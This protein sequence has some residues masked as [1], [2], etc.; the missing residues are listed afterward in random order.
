MRTV[1]EYIVSIFIIMVFFIAGLIVVLQIPVA[2]R[3]SPMEIISLSYPSTSGVCPGDVIP[4]QITFSIDENS[5]VI[6]YTAILD[7]GGNV[8]P[9]TES[10]MPPRP[11]AAG[12][13]LR[14][15]INF[16]VPDLQAGSYTRETAIA[17][18][19]HD[20]EVTMVVVPFTISPLCESN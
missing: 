4:I 11:H 19:T 6:A 8:V 9:G 3:D 17:S 1:A 20:S 10:S 15:T 12:V 16:V 18:R 5:V 2:L 13:I 7:V 14:Q